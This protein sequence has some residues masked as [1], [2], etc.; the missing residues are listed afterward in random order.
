MQNPFNSKL[1]DVKLYFL[2]LICLE[3]RPKK[4]KA[5]FNE[6]FDIF[7][8]DTFFIYKNDLCIEI[9]FRDWLLTY[10]K[11]LP[12]TVENIKD[13]ILYAQMMA[14]YSDPYE[15]SKISIIENRMFF[16]ACKFLQ[17]R[18]GHQPL[19]YWNDIL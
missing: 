15:N 12:L 2:N 7:I 1:I 11:C 14:V 9:N 3:N 8:Q 19:V 10:P 17:V 18:Q 16:M 4:E 6:V 13:F 5:I